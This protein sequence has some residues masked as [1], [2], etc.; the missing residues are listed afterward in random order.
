MGCGDR[1]DL[2]TTSVMPPSE[3]TK[4]NFPVE[5]DGVAYV[6]NSD[7]VC[8]KKPEHEC[9][10]HGKHSDWMV[11]IGGDWR[12]KT[13]CVLCIIALIESKGVTTHTQ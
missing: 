13:F 6:K 5:Q 4:N 12:S 9:P 7:V 2:P 1:M 11:Y 10:T 8:F 3:D